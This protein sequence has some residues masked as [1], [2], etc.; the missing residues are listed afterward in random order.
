MTGAQAMTPTVM[1]VG[2]A[3]RSRRATRA[4]T[5]EVVTTD[6]VRRMLQAAVQA[7]TAMHLEPWAFVVV[8]DPA[9]LQRISARAR[10]LPPVIADH[11][12]LVLAA[13]GEDLHLAVGFDIFYDAGTLIVIC[14]R[15][16]SAFDDA[17]C[18][19]AAQ[20]LMLTACSMG[21]ATCPIGFAVPAL[22]DAEIK[23]LL[24]I[25]DEVRAVAP[26][27]VGTARVAP[28]P[29]PRREPEILAWKL[30]NG[31]TSDDDHDGI[32]AQDRRP[33]PGPHAPPGVDE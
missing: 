1:T 26:I 33:Y 32:E 30:A 18:W 17:D 19:L 20:N 12:A 4:Y 13:G 27:I 22:N 9:I 7:P 10:E 6:A 23:S 11:R 25:P 2:D 3:I 14:A 31:R 24:D 8:Q 5:G 28:R 15:P 29:S 16:R 21:Y